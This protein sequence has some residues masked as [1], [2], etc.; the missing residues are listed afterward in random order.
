MTRFLRALLSFAIII[1]VFMIGLL[2][3]QPGTVDLKDV[4]LYVAVI[5][6][7]YWMSYV[8]FFLF[9]KG[10][11]LSNLQWLVTIVLFVTLILTLYVGEMRYGSKRWLKGVQ[12]SEFSKL[13][14]LPGLFKNS[15]IYLLVGLVSAF[16]VV[17][18]PD[19]GTGLIIAASVFIGFAIRALKAKSGVILWTIIIAAVI[20]MPVFFSYSLELRQSVVV[21]IT[22]MPLFHEHWE[23]RF[24]NWAN[25]LRDPFGESYQTLSAL[26][27]LGQS[28]GFGKGIGMLTTLP[29][30]WA[31]Y[32]FAELVR[33]FGLLSGLLVLM[34]LGLLIQLIL[35]W[36]GRS[37]YYVAAVLMLH[38]VVNLYTVANV[39]PA[40][41]IPLPFV[42]RALQNSVV[43]SAL[44]GAALGEAA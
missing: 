30:A 24:Q 23:D 1:V 42:G 44:T 15:G 28:S 25:P 12:V 18:E 9:R 5:S 4:G 14:L 32:A 6:A 40:T 2:T 35:N 10:Q 34:L 17:L 20:I 13:L 36:G 33:K 38:V 41:G 19:L 7:A 21:E 16:L 27:S 11:I 31:D 37:K 8:F 43:L 29:V 26:N 22:K 3:W 39:L